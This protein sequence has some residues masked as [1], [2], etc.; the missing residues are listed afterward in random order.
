MTRDWDFGW[1]PVHRGGQINQPISAHQIEQ[2]CFLFFVNHWC[3]S[4]AWY[5]IE[6]VPNTTCFKGT[7][8]GEE[9]LVGGDIRGVIL[10][11]HQLQLFPKCKGYAKGSLTSRIPFFF[12]V[13]FFCK[14]SIKLD[15]RTIMSVFQGKADSVRDRVRRDN[16]VDS[17]GGSWVR[18]CSW[19]WR[20]EPSEMDPPWSMVVNQGLDVGQKSIKIGRDI[21]QR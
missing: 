16:I 21:E 4:W 12:K 13:P 17:N 1:I 3:L 8:Q 14:A 7:R 5:K 20:V 10:C 19:H 18:E 9:L 15:G 2:G 11:K 6:G